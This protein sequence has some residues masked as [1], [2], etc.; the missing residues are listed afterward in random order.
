MARKYDEFVTSKT[1][2]HN[3]PTTCSD[4][5]ARKLPKQLV[6]GSMAQHIIHFLEPVDVEQKYS[7]PLVVGVSIDSRVLNEMLEA[8][9][10]HQSRQRISRGPPF[11]SVDQDIQ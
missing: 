3:T 11:K 5:L 4:K 1:G 8:G 6:P 10:V 2:D 7:S 9:P